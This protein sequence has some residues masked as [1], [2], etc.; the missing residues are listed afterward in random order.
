M[1]WQKILGRAADTARGRVASAAGR[2]VLA[3]RL[4]P[5]GDMLNFQIDPA[6]KSIALE[7]LLKGESEPV[8][9]TLSGYELR[10]DGGKT[11]LTFAGVTASREWIETLVREFVIGREIELPP[12]LAPVLRLLV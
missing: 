9:L 11:R 2:Q 5:Y 12:K 4:A 6:A 3:S 8:R 1:S 10:D 7:I